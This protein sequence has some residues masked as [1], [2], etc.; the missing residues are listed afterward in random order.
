MTVALRSPELLRAVIPVDNVP[1]NA[2]LKSD[3]HKYVKGMQD[4]EEQRPQKQ[5]EADAILENYEKERKDNSNLEDSTD[6]TI[7]ADS[8]HPAISANQ[9]RSF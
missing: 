6:L 3:F 2:N 4:I 9:P 8:G 1:V 5:A 7:T